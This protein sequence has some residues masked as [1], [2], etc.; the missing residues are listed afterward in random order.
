MKKIALI[1]LLSTT[2]FAES[3]KD[4]YAQFAEVSG[5]NSVLDGMVDEGA[6]LAE[7]TQQFKN[8]AVSLDK[9]TKNKLT[10][11]IKNALTQ[12]KI[13]IENSTFKTYQ[14][15]FS[16]SDLRELIS[17]YQTAIGKKV[18]AHNP[19]I[20]AESQRF[21]EQIMERFYP[22]IIEQVMNLMLENSAK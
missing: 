17:F 19:A 1:F 4:T 6:I 14:R 11:I 3:Y 13:E 9:D 22:Q 10:Q 8:S 15:H 21:T 16:Q 12:A 7:I 2:I 20:I 5:L 18:A